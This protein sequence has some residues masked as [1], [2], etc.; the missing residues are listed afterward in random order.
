MVH[1]Y[2]G[3]FFKPPDPRTFLYHLTAGF[4]A[5]DNSLVPFGT[6]PLVFPVNRADIAAADSGRLGLNQYLSPTRG[7]DWILFKNSG[8]V[9]RK[10]SPLHGSLHIILL[11]RLES[12]SNFG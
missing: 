9:S 10:E 7:R 2:P 12:F 11:I 5:G 6:L 8:T 4:V 1:H 3:T